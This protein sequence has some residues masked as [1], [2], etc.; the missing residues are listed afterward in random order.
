M[1]DSEILM[2]RAQRLDSSTDADPISRSGLRDQ[3]TQR[4]LT[5]VFERR[6]PS[7]SRLIV[8]RLA[9]RFDVSPTPIREALIELAGLGIVELLP[10]RGALVRPFGAQELTQISQVRRVLETEACRTACGKIDKDA[11][12]D[13]RSGL[14]KL[15][16]MPRN[17]DWDRS[18]RTADSRLHF[19]IA[20]GSGNPRLAYEIKRYLS[21]FRSMRNISHVRDSWTNY[22]RSNDVPDHLR[23]AEALVKGNRERAAMAMDWHIRNITKVLTEIV[24]QPDAKALPAESMIDGR[25]RR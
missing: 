7:G 15:Q 14:K 19:L 11:L 8:Q 16:K 4:I 10:N 13:L 12:E 22:Q 2:K 1:K 5:E 6:L 3:V 17:A 25:T 21:L 23:I 20:D 18:A 24:F 9:E